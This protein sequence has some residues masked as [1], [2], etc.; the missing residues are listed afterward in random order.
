[1]SYFMLLMVFCSLALLQWQAGRALARPEPQPLMR[2]VQ[3]HFKV[4]ITCDILN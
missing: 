1:M 4:N 2:R 3:C